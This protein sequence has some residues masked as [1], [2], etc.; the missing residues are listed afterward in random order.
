[1]EESAQPPRCQLDKV[2]HGSRFY[3]LGG[4]QAV[5]RRRHDLLKRM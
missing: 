4:I 1:M 3:G 2:A 5:F